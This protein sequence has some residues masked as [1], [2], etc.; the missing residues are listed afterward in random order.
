[1]GEFDKFNFLYALASFCSGSAA[2]LGAI[3][4]LSSIFPV[5]KI[6]DSEKLLGQRLNELLSISFRE[7][8]SYE[9]SVM[10]RLQLLNVAKSYKH[11]FD[12]WNFQKESYQNLISMAQNISFAVQYLVIAAIICF[13]VA[14]INVNFV[15]I[16]LPIIFLGI[17]YVIFKIKHKDCFTFSKITTMRETFFKSIFFQRNEIQYP[18]P[19]K[20]FYPCYYEDTELKNQL[21]SSGE[22][23]DILS[24]RAF[25]MVS[26]MEIHGK[27]EKLVGDPELRMTKYCMGASDDVEK[28][29]IQSF[30]CFYIPALMK[31]DDDST[32]T[33]QCNCIDINWG[34]RTF[35]IKTDALKRFYKDK[36]YYELVLR[37]TI[38]PEKI[39][40]VMV[41]FE[42][43]NVT[44]WYK[45]MYSE[46]PNILTCYTFS[47]NGGTYYNTLNFN[48]VDSV[49]VEQE[50][51]EAEEST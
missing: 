40:K 42:N 33:V 24:M 29:G 4:A 20:L 49:L 36:D 14:L 19:G 34:N 31:L 30:I 5:S 25:S 8:D 13:I 41:E 45:N 17:I 38:P 32:I 48:Y 3:L 2:I 35:K 46:K 11:I 16:L 15:M 28:Y 6:D 44:F 1:M 10:T 26:F 22:K 23:L 43:T 37:S 50:K 27:S 7:V 47:W 18:Q 12:E 51:K 21:P 9:K 39:H